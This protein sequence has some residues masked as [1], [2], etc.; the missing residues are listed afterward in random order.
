M[1]FLLLVSALVA[2]LLLLP[3]LL[4]GPLRG[5]LADPDS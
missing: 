2:D 1:M 3:A 5:T 4:V